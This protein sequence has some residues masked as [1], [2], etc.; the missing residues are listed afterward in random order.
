M[1]T[2]VF[3]FAEPE[4]SHEEISDREKL[5]MTPGL[6]SNHDVSESNLTKAQDGDTTDEVNTAFR[7]LIE[8]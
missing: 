2:C 8:I 4:P 7:I 5:T 3:V 1:M 6:E